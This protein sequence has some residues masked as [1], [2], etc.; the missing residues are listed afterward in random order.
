MLNEKRIIP[1]K[2]IRFRS[3]VTSVG[4]GNTSSDNV[5]PIKLSDKL[6]RQIAG[7]LHSAINK[8][9]IVGPNSADVEE[10]TLTIAKACA[11]FLAICART[12]LILLG[13]KVELPTA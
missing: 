10:K 9:P 8:P 6:F 5:K 7:Q 4:L 3:N 12:K 2:S 1:V 11:C 13:N